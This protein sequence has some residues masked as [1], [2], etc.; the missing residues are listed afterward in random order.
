MTIVRI[1]SNVVKRPTLWRG[2][3]MVVRDAVKFL[4]MYR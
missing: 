1:R 2:P 4:P 3:V